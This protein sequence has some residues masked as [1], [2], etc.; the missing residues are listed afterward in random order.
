MREV[1]I[2][3]VNDKAFDNDSKI[4]KTWF[5]LKLKKLG[6]E[7]LNKIVYWETN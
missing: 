2:F 4:I 6:L 1:K 3:G 7:A 5:A